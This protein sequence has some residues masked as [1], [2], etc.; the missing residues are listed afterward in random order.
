MTLFSTSVHNVGLKC[1]VFLTFCRV[2]K[3]ALDEIRFKKSLFNTFPIILPFSLYW[4]SIFKTLSLYWALYFSLRPLEALYH[5]RRCMLTMFLLICWS[6]VS[7]PREH[8][9]HCRIYNQWMPQKLKSKYRRSEVSF[10][11]HNP[12]V[13]ITGHCFIWCIAKKLN[14]IVSRQ[15]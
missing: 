14:Q 10:T 6:R 11:Y 9:K 13:I 12:Q 3:L 2:A 1:I 15:S 8:R 7:N 5:G 4:P